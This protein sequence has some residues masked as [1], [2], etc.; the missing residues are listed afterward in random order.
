MTIERKIGAKSFLLAHGQ[1]KGNEFSPN[2]S[3][4]PITTRASAGRIRWTP[5]VMATNR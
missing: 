1:E 2:K 4:Q 5:I 3:F